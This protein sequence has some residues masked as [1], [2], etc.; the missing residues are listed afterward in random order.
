MADST[1]G[2]AGVKGHLYKY[3]NNLLGSKPDVQAALNMTA[4]QLQVP[5]CQEGG[6]G[7]NAALLN[8]QAA[9]GPYGAEQGFIHDAL[10]VR[11]Q[12]VNARQGKVPEISGG[13]PFA[14][15]QTSVIPFIQ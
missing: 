10:E 9:P 3:F 11:S 7:A 6:K 14:H 5:Q 8:V 4:E 2:N 13:H 12:L 15:F 1:A